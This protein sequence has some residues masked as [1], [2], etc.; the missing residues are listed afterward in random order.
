KLSASVDLLKSL[1]VLCTKAEH[2]V[3]SKSI[4]GSFDVLLLDEGSSRAVRLVSSKTRE[5]NQV[6]EHSTARSHEAFA[7]LDETQKQRVTLLENLDHEIAA[8]FVAFDVDPR[9]KV[10]E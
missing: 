9:L 10:V 2:E 7:R 4:D 8:S 5:L 3:A 1:Q 6:A